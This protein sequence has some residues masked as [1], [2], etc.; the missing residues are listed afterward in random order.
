MNMPLYNIVPVVR[1]S[2]LFYHQFFPFMQLKSK[3]AT[4]Y[5]H[6][7]VQQPEQH[8]TQHVNHLHPQPQQHTPYTFPSLHATFCDIIHEAM[9]PGNKD[10][11]QS[12]LQKFDNDAVKAQGL[13]EQ[14]HEVMAAAHK[15]CM[16][17]IRQLFDANRARSE[18]APW[19]DETIADVTAWSPSCS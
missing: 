5:H 2:H 6:V 17:A 13:M 14:A 19:N 8:Q 10:R 4:C 3:S 16:S 9:E 11:V 15:D 12:I 18:N 1:T 7:P